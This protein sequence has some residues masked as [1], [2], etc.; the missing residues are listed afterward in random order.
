MVESVRRRWG[1]GAGLQ[2]RPPTREQQ[3]PPQRVGPAQARGQNNFGL[4]WAPQQTQN[5]SRQVGQLAVCRTGSTSVQ[6]PQ[7]RRDG[8]GHGT[9]QAG[10]ALME[11][12]LRKAG[13][14][15]RQRG[16]HQGGRTDKITQPRRARP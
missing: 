15:A 14:K 12:Q 1:T 9:A 13:R 4:G 10:A 8:K 2:E 11:G 3:T 7:K 5:G 16:Q 6:E